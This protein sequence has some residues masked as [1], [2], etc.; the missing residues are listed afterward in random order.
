M[1]DTTPLPLPEC[2][3]EDC[4]ANVDHWHSIPDGESAPCQLTLGNH[5]SFH[6]DPEVGCYAPRTQPAP[7]RPPVTVI[8]AAELRAALDEEAQP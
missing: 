2:P 1:P 4:A 8:D 3:R 6:V 7:A 5:C